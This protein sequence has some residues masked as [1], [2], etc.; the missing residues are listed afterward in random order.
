LKELL[1]YLQGRNTRIALYVYDAIVFD[2]SKK[3][4]KETLEKIQKIME[5]GGRYPIKV[6]YGNSLDL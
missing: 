2:F 1:Q 5:S 3:D 6:K 4:G